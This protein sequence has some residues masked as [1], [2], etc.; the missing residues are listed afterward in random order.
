MDK[1]ILQSVPFGFNKHF[2]HC[3]EYFYWV[4]DTILNDSNYMYIVMEPDTKMGKY[5]YKSK[6]CGIIS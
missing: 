4:T 2:V 3:M 1:I 6:I 5:G